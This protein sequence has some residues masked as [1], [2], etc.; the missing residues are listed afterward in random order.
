[1]TDYPYDPELPFVVVQVQSDDTYEFPVGSI[2][3]RFRDASS[4]REY[5]DG[6]MKGYVEFVD[7]NPAPKIPADAEFI[8]WYDDA[9]RPYYA[10]RWGNPAEKA[11]E[12]DG[13]KL[14]NED[15]LAKQWIGDAEVVVLKRA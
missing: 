12:T 10:R 11:W 2:N 13:G 7:T 5:A 3:A 4:A 1:M 14:V 9:E 15:E 6:F 8:F